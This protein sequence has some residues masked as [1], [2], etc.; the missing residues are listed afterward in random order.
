ME[1]KHFVSEEIMKTSIVIPDTL[2]VRVQDFNRL[3]PDQPINVSGVCRQALEIKL[4][5]VE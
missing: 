1:L 2:L 4:K 5:E 3:H